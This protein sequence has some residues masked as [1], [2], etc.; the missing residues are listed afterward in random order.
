MD[1]Q[2]QNYG[3]AGGHQGAHQGQRGPV[4]VMTQEERTWSVL[5]HLS[6]F[7]NLVTGFLGPVAALVVWLVFRDRSRRVAFN[8][9]Q[10]MW[11]QVAWVVILAVGWTVTGLLT[12]VL[13]G[14]LLIPVMALVSIVPFVHAAY[15]AYR[16][17]RDGEYRYP[18]IADMIESR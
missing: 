15:A 7:L 18:F 4:V 10:S 6:M 17:S 1:P 9:L 2:Q 14:F 12:I 11:Y 13:I 8:A 16:V 5:A 3:M